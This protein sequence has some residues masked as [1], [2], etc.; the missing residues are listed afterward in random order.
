MRLARPQ[1][2]KEDI[3]NMNGTELTAVVDAPEIQ[4][5]YLALKES[6]TG[7]ATLDPIRQQYQSP[8]PD[9]TYRI[10]LAE[11]TSHVESYSFILDAGSRY[12]PLLEINYRRNNPTRN[13]A[14]RYL[15]DG[16]G[17]YY[18][19]HS[20]AIKFDGERPESFNRENLLWAS[21]GGYVTEI[22]WPNGETEEVL[23]LG[24]IGSEALWTA[25][26]LYVDAVKE[27]KNMAES[28]AETP[29]GQEPVADEYCYTPEAQARRTFHRPA[30]DIEAKCIHRLVI[31]SLEQ[32][33]RARGSSYRVCNDRPRD[34]FTVSRAG[35][36]TVLFE[37]KASVTSTDIY[38]G[39]GQLMLHG[40]VG[41]NVP[42]RVL[43]LPGT[44]K[45]ETATR[46]ERLGIT[47]LEYEYDGSKVIF[48]SDNIE[49]VLENGSTSV[50]RSINNGESNNDRD[51]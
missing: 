17:N 40:A 31:D 41:N 10:G 44:P 22:A 1:P 8:R 36:V 16:L 14:G 25:I 11:T 38:T 27:I 37:A 6:L 24:R 20:G 30:A 29:P 34:L 13:M 49:E 7:H 26:L 21:R 42:K 39:V 23:I 45:A 43:V 47:V 33:I 32:A 50:E 48:F 5:C 9:I 18:L 4:T 19:G 2:R 46:L 28:G 15:R 35:R 12:D 51:E 3:L